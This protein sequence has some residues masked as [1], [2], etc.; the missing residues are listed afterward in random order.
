MD[1]VAFEYDEILK[2]IKLN[3]NSITSDAMQKL[4]F[5][6]EINYGLAIPELDRILSTL[7]KN[8]ELAMLCWLQPVRESKLLAL[9]LFQ[10][11]A[12][13]QHQ[14]E[15]VVGGITNI[16]LAEQ[17][18]LRFFVNFEQKVDIARLLIHH[19][20]TFVQYCGLMTIGNLAKSSTNI[21]ENTFKK[22]LDD[23]QEVEWEN[24]TYIKRGLALA[25]LKI[26]LKNK[27]LEQIVLY[28]INKFEKID[29]NITEWLKQEVVYYLETKN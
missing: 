10:Y 7:D 6:Y 12:V 18:A 23:M 24:K 21:D 15:I 4:S 17:A 8:N 3:K 20:N 11:Q 27:S 5:G 28:W 1:E 13:T 16:E 25:L 14:I 2:K 19:S 26:G 29:Q 9:R 22:I